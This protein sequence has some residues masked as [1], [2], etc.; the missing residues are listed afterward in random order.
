MADAVPGLQDI[1]AGIYSAIVESQNTIEQHYLGEIERDYFEDGKPKML[2]V[3]LP[4]HDGMLQELQIPAITLVPHHGLKIK[5]VTLEM[6]VHLGAKEDDEES[7][8][9]GSPLRKL[10]SGFRGK[11]EEMSTIKITFEGTDPPEGLARI[12]DSLV[13][14]IPT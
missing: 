10:V 7:T 11:Q 9:K 8:G 12:K 1:F 14:F 5:E 13:K 2:A 6:K 3:S 4:G